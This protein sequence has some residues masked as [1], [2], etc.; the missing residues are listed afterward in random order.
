MVRRYLGYPIF[1]LFFL[2]QTLL[3]IGFVALMALRGC[4]LNS[5]Q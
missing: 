2:V 5:P 4:A 3:I 1:E